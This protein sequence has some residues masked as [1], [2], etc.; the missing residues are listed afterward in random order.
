MVVDLR[1][2]PATISPA[3]ARAAAKGVAYDQL[4]AVLVRGV[5]LGMKYAAP[6]MIRQRSG[7]IINIASVAAHRAGPTF[8]QAQFLDRIA[9]PENPRARRRDRGGHARGRGG[10]LAGHARPGAAAEATGQ[11]QQARQ[12]Y[13]DSGARASSSHRHGILQPCILSHS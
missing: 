8:P 2:E 4:M 13:P 5:M 1:R 3:E 7:S 11:R 6:F 12:A 9:V 10:G